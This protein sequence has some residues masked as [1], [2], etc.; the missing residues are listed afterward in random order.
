MQ[1][2]NHLDQIHKRISVSKTAVREAKPQL[3]WPV[4]VERTVALGV[5]ISSFSVTMRQRVS[6]D[7]M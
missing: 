1:L 3:P 6:P 4:S 7:R 5:G 2:R